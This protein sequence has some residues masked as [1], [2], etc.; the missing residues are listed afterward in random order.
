MRLLIARISTLYGVGQASGKPQ[1]LLT[2]MS[3]CLIR[4]EAIQIYV[5]LD[6]IRDYIMADDAAA[7]VIET[8]RSLAPGAAVMRIVASEQ[9]ATISE[10]VSIFKRIARR[11]PR[12]VKSDAPA[13][14]VYS[15]RIQ[16]RSLLPLSGSR[17]PT[18]LLVGISQVL[19]AERLRYVLAERRSSPFG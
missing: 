4:N 18:S 19:A 14:S 7:N 6:T 8:A 5:S 17:R 11:P 9:P 12:I 1:G 2:H 16:F 15:R 13:S 3:R 10:I